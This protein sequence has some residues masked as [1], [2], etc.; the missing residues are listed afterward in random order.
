[1]AVREAVVG[2]V[3]DSLDGQPDDDQTV[4]VAKEDDSVHGF[5]TVTSERHWTGALDGYI[6][7][8]VVASTAEGKGTGSAL[9]RAAIEWSREQGFGR[10]T[11]ATG[12]AN[13]RARRVYERLGFQE[14]GITLSLAT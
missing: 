11:V 5:I 3:E 1:M 2:W 9:V 7:E 6:G 12:A 14:E 4:L 10:V 13:Q 8:L